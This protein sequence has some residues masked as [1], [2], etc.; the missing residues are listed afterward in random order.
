VE[1]DSKIMVSYLVSHRGWPCMTGGI[2]VSVKVHSDLKDSEGECPTCRLLVSIVCLFSPLTY[3]SFLRYSTVGTSGRSCTL[4]RSH[5]GT[6]QIAITGEY[7]AGGC[8]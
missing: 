6:D 2:E 8:Q 7:A 3:F 1:S 5:Q 4:S